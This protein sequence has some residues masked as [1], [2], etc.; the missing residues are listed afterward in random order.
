[1]TSGYD[2]AVLRG[3]SRLFPTR[4]TYLFLAAGFIAF[5]VYASLLP[6]DLR[7]IPLA[8]A[9][10]T[11]RTT[12]FG[13]LPARLSRTDFLANVLLFLPVG[14]ALTGSV[15]ADRGWRFGPLRALPI[16]LPIS[17][18]ASVAAEFLQTFTVRRVPTSV[19]ILAQ[20]IGCLVGVLAWA[21]AGGA[22][23]QWIRQTVAASPE[24]RL[25]RALTAYAAAWVFVSLAPF[26]ITLDLGLLSQRFRSGQIALIPFSDTTAI[27]WRA[28]WDMLAEML[29]AVPLGL[30]GVAGW[31]RRRR[32]SKTAAFF[33]G[34][35]LVAIVEMAQV[36][37]RSHSATATDMLFGCAGVTLGL[38]AGQ[39]SA[40]E[41]ALTATAGRSFSPTATAA[42]A[43]WSLVVAAYH[44]QPFNFVF[45]P[46]LIKGRLARL[47]LVPF[48][49][50][51][52]GPSLN[53]LNDVLTKL[54]LAIPAGVIAAWIVRQPPSRLTGAMV[55]AWTLVAGLIFSGVELG[56][57][58]LPTRLPDPTDVVTAVIGSIVGL[59]AGA[60][61]RGSKFR[62]DR[63]A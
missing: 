4:R 38:A 63:R 62:Q 34:A 3:E 58:F 40:R 27:T 12:I 11:L 10:H 49:A 29:A 13:P 25:S 15:L 30:L 8:D 56:Q 1:M 17:V 26:D 44:W 33:F 57:F 22:L 48:A 59:M 54:A 43:L 53:A 19:D 16:V 37:V 41:Q 32:R 55:A 61:V 39:L 35:A 5:A 24:D 7:P 45:D 60:W 2:L 21:L 14:F 9:V 6:F 51:A 28:G 31:N 47:S 50:Y 20:T 36:F 46:G 23:T 18:A 42:L 52:S